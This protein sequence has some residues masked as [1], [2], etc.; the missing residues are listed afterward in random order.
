MSPHELN[1]PVPNA[2][3]TDPRSPD[4]WLSLATVPILMGVLGG[5]GILQAVQELGQLSEEIFRGDRL[6]LLTFP[7]TAIEQPETS[8]SHANND[9]TSGGNSI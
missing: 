6:P 5:R 7:P 4:L 9:A 1:E 8:D 2:P 3:S